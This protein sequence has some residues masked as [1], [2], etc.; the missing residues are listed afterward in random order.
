MAASPTTTVEI[1][2]ELL[3]Q[4]RARD[5]RKSDRQLVEDLAVVTLGFETVRE[6]QERNAGADED[7]VMAEAVKAAREVRAEM[8]A[9]RRAAG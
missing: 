9:E 7:E 6:V 4:L 8:A 2:S 1:N 3:K 5:R